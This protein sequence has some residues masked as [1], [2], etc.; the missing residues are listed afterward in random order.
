MAV[1]YESTTLW[2]STLAERADDQYK[3]QRDR[4]RVSYQQVRQRAGDL[5]GQVSGHISGLTQHDI[6]HLDGLWETGST[7][8]G[9]DYPINPL[10]GYVLGAAFLLHDAALCPEAYQGGLGGLRASV[11]WT[12]ALAAHE[13]RKPIATEEELNYLADFEALRVLHAKQAEKLPSM[14][15]QIPGGDELYLI[16]DADLRNHLGVLIGQLAASHHWPIEQV[17]ALPQQVNSILDFP[18]DWSIDPIKLACIVRCA[19]AAHISRD[20]APDFLFALIERS[21]LSLTHWKA[22]NVLTRFAIDAQRSDTLIIGS[23]K[24][25]SAEDQSAWW[26]AYDAISLVQKE[27]TS[28][29]ALLATRANSPEF[30]AKRISGVDSPAQLVNHVTV[31]GWEPCSAKLHVSNVAG[32]VRNLGGENLYGTNQDL[33]QIVIREL[34]QNSRDAISAR[35]ALYGDFDA[36]IR[37]LLRAEED[38]LWLD[39]EDN[40]IGMSK[41]V[42]TG[43]LLDFGTSFWSTYLVQEVFPGL[44]SSEFNSV[45]EFGI[46]FY[47]SFMIADEARIRTR[48]W[49]GG[50]QD[51]HEIEFRDG[52]SLRPLLRS[53][54][55]I[56]NYDPNCSTR[57]S[58]RLN[59]AAVI[60]IQD[61]EIRHNMSQQA[62]FAVSMG[63]YVAALVIGL[64]EDV[65]LDENDGNG[66]QKVHS[67]QFST[68]KEDY[69]KWLHLIHVSKDRPAA[70]SPGWDVESYIDNHAARLRVIEENGEVLGL[71]A[72]QTWATGGPS[73]LQTVGGLA[74]R[75]HTRGNHHFFGY[76]ECHPKSAKR[77]AGK[78]RMSNGAL[79]VW[80]E[81]QR[82][83]LRQQP[84]DMF[85]M[86]GTASS[87]AKYDVDPIEFA[88]VQFKLNESRNW[89]TVEMLVKM[90]Q[91]GQPVGILR[92]QKHGKSTSV[93]EHPET[94]VALMQPLSIFSKYGNAELEHG[95]PKEDYSLIGCLHR[96]AENKG[97]KVTWTVHDG[98][99][100]DTT[101]E[102]VDLVVCTTDGKHAISNRKPK[103]GK[104]ESG[105]KR[106]PLSPNDKAKRKRERKQKKK[107][108]KQNRK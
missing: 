96:S 88:A 41:R 42:L 93:R 62:P 81:E 51:Q 86:E 17:A 46:G 73:Q 38:A 12:D 34:I 105:S 21:G 66:L 45:G 39:V 26:V 20:R 9:H 57:I 2:Q 27:I 16:E 102:Y 15:W 22:Q 8:A 7:I 24:G 75:I 92:S 95:R 1:A 25:F 104:S 107:A 23:T 4:L 71:A 80:A 43:P 79:K 53:G 84:L 11:A 70:S 13:R 48:K 83:I 61:P 50:Q 55:D 5:V 19:D 32:L 101:H 49:D 82:D 64:D 6:S 3:A 52:L 108:R 60:K 76:M 97:L 14:K 36:Q 67:R 65:F 72:L 98:F 59:E 69:A 56:P 103:A 63:D 77:D 54:N 68:Q 47:S 37:V 85:H 94:E 44:R 100:K 87:L 10:E 29:N 31:E 30:Q 91:Q 89:A 18:V 78:L 58:L 99:A 90:L 106:K 35:R 40:G 28:S 74:T 33:L